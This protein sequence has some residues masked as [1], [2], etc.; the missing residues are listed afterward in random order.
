M[1]TGIPLPHPTA[2]SKPFWEGTRAGKLLL[3]RCK[4]CGAYRWTP[5]QLCIQC[6]SEAYEWTPVSGRGTV[7]SHTTVERPPLAAFAPGYV[8][9]VVQLDEGPLMLTNLVDCP[10]D[11]VAVGLPVEVVFEKASDEITFYKFKPRK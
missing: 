5:Q 6:H 2:L 1:T 10:P 9:A 7:Y 3:Q 8:I 11:K 4:D